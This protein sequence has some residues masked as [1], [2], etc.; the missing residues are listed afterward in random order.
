MKF[1]LDADVCIEAMR[2]TRGHSIREHLRQCNPEDV[3]ISCVVQAELLYGALHSLESV[4]NLK[5][6]WNFISNFASLSFD[7]MAADHAAQ[8]RQTLSGLGTPIG[9]NDV[10]IAGAARSQGVILVTRNVRE[11]SRVPGL[12]IE[13]WGD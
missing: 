4:E 5:R 13:N 6:T 7:T 3:G 8:I 9:P 1:L 10:L 11:F 2:R 12:Q